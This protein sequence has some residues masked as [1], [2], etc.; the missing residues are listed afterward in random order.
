MTSRYKAMIFD[1]DGTLLDSMLLW[2][3]VWKEYIAKNGIATPAELVGKS[4]YGCMKSCGLIAEQEGRDREEIYA[5]MRQ[6]IQAHYMSDIQ[7]KPHAGELLE[8]LKA[9]GYTVGVATATLRDMAYPA[10][11][12]HGLTK[13]IDFFCDVDEIGLSKSDP[14]FFVRTAALAGAKPEDCVMFEDAV[15]AMRSAK[16]AGLSLVAIE[17]PMSRR[18]REEILS[19]ADRYVLSWDEVIKSLPVIIDK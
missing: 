8:A 16:A 5:E 10:L 3:T 11:E 4:D 2:R 15:Y 1:M 6:L 14:E 7:P 12:R 17:E 19:L 13:H 18:D 9:E